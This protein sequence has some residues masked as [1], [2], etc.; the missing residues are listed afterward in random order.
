MT[1]KP[2]SPFSDSTTP[3][4]K[5]PWGPIVITLVSTVLLGAGSCFGFVSTLSFGGKNSGASV[6]FLSVFALC[7]LAFIGAL[8][9]A[10]IAWI[11]GR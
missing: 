9:W 8:L 4:P 6:V 3:R 11:R 7:V 2:N 1:N 5:S 10:L